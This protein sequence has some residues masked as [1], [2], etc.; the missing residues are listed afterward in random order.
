[1]IFEA[2]G[3][4][5]SEDP[6][7]TA[8]TGLRFTHFIGLA[9]GLGGAT[10]LDLMLLRFC[11]KGRIQTETYSIVAFSSKIIAAGLHILWLSGV[12]FLLFYA[13]YDVAKLYNPKVHAKIAVVMILMVNGVFIH[14]V[15][16]PTIRS[17]IGRPLFEG[18]GLMKRSIFAVSGAIS[19][20]SWY[21]P[22]A[23]GVFSQFN[24]SVPA[25][26]ILSAY[27]LLILLVG[28]AIGFALHLLDPGKRQVSLQPGE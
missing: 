1:M 6:V 14:H 27:L 21:V 11:L 4:V 7:T 18:L 8:K 24:H 17:Q 2:I 10:L 5:F 23:L 3:Q 19:A 22:L 26:T 25:I 16:L 13:L 28:A 9:L 12:G 20:V 15:I